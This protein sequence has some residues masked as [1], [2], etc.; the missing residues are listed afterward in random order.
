[1]A[2]DFATLCLCVSVAIA[3]CHC[4]LLLPIASA[5]CCCILFFHSPGAQVSSPLTPGALVLSCSG[6]Q[7]T[8]THVPSNLQR[9]STLGTSRTI[10]F[11]SSIQTKAHEGHP[12]NPMS[13]TQHLADEDSS[14]RNS[15]A[16]DKTFAKGSC[17]P[18]GFSLLFRPTTRIS[19]EV[20]SFL[21]ILKPSLEGL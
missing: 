3:H 5:Y 1:M 12:S 15:R 2:T 21:K 8:L 19:L 11:D 17:A 9:T 6:A 13:T 16:K 4:L 14:C 18:S 20:L 7:V 10:A